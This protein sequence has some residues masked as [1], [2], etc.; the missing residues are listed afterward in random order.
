MES[1]YQIFIGSEAS[2][3]R[4]S[5]TDPPLLSYMDLLIGGAALIGT[6]GC[7]LIFRF[8]YRRWKN[9][10]PSHTPSAV[11]LSKN[12]GFTQHQKRV[13]AQKIQET[14]TSNL[15]KSFAGADNSNYMILA[16]IGLIVVAL[17]WLLHAIS[18]GFAPY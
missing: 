13:L 1:I 16:T 18:K 17:L 2:I 4:P 5:Y 3:A 9:R 7:V 11:L 8:L 10:Q 15:K 6:V 14:R 12:K